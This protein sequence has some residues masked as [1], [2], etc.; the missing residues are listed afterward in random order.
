MNRVRP[1]SVIVIGAGFAGLAAALRLARAGAQVTVL[2]RLERPGGKAALGWA[3]FSSGP[4]VVTMPQI[5][6]GL[7]QR[8][9]WGEPLLTPARPTTTYH[10]AG[11]LSGRTF[12]PEALNVAGSLDST[13][14]QLS[15]REGRAYTRLLGA[16]RRMYQGAAPTFLFGPPPG[17]LKLARYAL[18]HGLGAAPGRTLAQFVRSGP[19]LTPFWLR[20]GTYLGADPYQAPAVLHNVA[21]V[22][23]GQGVWHLGEGEGAGL[24]YFA[25]QLGEEARTLGVRFEQG[26]TVKHLIRS[27]SRI[28][29]VHVLLKKDL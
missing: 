21:W 25:A 5:F 19:L 1:R 4:T 22:E 8:L 11:K 7:H 12:A 28:M 17:K 15:A 3:D 14:S 18:R 10:Y 26:V 29:G 2:D 23:L 27:G 20:F 24:G 9:G 16:S 6:R 13:L